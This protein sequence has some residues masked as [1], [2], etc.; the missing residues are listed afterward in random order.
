[1]MAVWSGGQLKPVDRHVN[2]RHALIGKITGETNSFHKFGLADCPQDFEVLATTEDGNLEA[3]RHSIL[4]WEG[5][6]WHPEREAKL[7][8]RDL[9]RL[10][11]LFGE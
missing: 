7:A 10:R 2:T 8:D 9:K 5:W 11:A 3:I 1:M 6:M 4:P